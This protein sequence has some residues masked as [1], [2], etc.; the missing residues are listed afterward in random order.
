MLGYFVGYHRVIE[1]NGV[2]R[3]ARL[4]TERDADALG[5][6]YDSLSVCLAGNFDVN[7]PTPAQAAKLGALLSHWCKLWGLEDSE[8]FPHRRFNPTSC[9]GARLSD[10]WAQ[11]IYLKYEILR[12]QR[13]FDALQAP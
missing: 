13:K 7:A 2:V 10:N 6:N 9:Y 12:L 8:I 4:D 5:H 11:L 3:Y 1:A